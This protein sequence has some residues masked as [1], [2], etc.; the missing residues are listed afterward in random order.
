[1]PATKLFFVKGD[2]IPGNSNIRSK[3]NENLCGT[4]EHTIQNHVHESQAVA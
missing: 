3:R 2:P 1:M 4:E